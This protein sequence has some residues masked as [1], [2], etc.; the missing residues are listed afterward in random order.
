MSLFLHIRNALSGNTQCALCTK[1]HKAWFSVFTLLAPLSDLIIRLWIAYTFFTAGLLKI[2]S[3]E[4]TMA[5]F[6]YEYK[7]PLLSPQTAAILGTG[8]ELILPLFLA[9]GLGGRLCVLSVFLYNAV[10]AL[11]YPFLWTPDGSIG[12]QQHIGWGLLL[13]SLLAHGLGKFSLDYFIHYRSTA[14]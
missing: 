1:A 10:A 8:A 9:L 4:T 3:W 12:L 5:L 6:R 13:L 11:S 7:V 14:S 2:Q